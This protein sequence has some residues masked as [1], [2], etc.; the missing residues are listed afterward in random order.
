M[1]VRWLW[2]L[3]GV[4]ITVTACWAWVDRPVALWVH[5]Q[6]SFEAE[7]S[8]LKPLAHIPDPLI[9][10]ACVLFVVLGLSALYRVQG[11]RGRNVAALSS[12]SMIVTETIKDGCKWLF[13]RPWPDNWHGSKP[14]FIGNG[15]YQFHWF[16][17]GGG[18]GAFPS[19]A[20]GGGNSTVG[21]PVGLLTCH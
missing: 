15:D 9:P 6:R 8:V 21:C 7:H 19:G 18:R 2:A 11:A 10:A 12:V 1:V 20:H 5:A 17:G 16:A 3:L 14:A 4:A 13:G